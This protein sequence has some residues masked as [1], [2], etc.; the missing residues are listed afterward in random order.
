MGTCKYC[1]YYEIDHGLCLR[2]GKHQEDGYYPEFGEF[3]C[4]FEPNTEY[5]DSIQWD[6]QWRWHQ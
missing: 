6:N 1:L 2:C 3:E 4:T 5:D